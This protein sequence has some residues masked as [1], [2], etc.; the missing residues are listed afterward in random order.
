[1]AFTFEI[2][3]KIY[4]FMRNAPLPCKNTKVYIKSDLE[5]NIHATP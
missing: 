4:T 1:M 5:P 3:A 2:I